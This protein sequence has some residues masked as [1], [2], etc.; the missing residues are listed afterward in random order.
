MSGTGAADY[1]PEQIG[2]SHLNCTRCPTSGLVE[3]LSHSESGLLDE[4]P[5]K[6]A[7]TALSS[8]VPDLWLVLDLIEPMFFRRHFFLL[9]L[10]VLTTFHLLQLVP[11]LSHSPSAPPMDHYWLTTLCGL[12][13]I[14]Y[15]DPPY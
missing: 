4:K 7:L 6:I 10:V 1:Y 12:H 14:F 5:Q 11:E 3:H 2:W 9:F 15:V 8:R 13:G